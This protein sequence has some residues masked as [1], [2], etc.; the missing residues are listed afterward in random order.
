M[1]CD[2]IQQDCV[3]SLGLDLERC[4][5]Q[6][7]CLIISWMNATVEVCALNRSILGKIKHSL[8]FITSNKHQY[9]IKQNVHN[10][11]LI[12]FNK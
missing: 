4:I 6:Y 11:L 12:I 3:K 7:H 1:N 5:F 2:F 8:I 10:D 9:Q